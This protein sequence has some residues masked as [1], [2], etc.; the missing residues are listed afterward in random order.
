MPKAPGALLS[1]RAVGV[2]GGH[3]RGWRPPLVFDVPFVHPII[4]GQLLGVLAV[5]T[6]P[7]QIPFFGDTF[8]TAWAGA[9]VTVAP[10][11]QNINGLIRQ[12]GVPVAGFVLTPGGPAYAAP[13][14]ITISHG[15]YFDVQLLQVG[16]PP[17]QGSHLVWVLAGAP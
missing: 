5:G 4:V 15:D 6:L 3:R 1:F 16:V 9:R 17:N 8:E 10:G 12:N 13:L 11:G 14:L 7:P 2:I